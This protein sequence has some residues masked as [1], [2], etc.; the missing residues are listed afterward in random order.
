MFESIGKEEIDSFI[1][2]NGQFVV[3][4][5]EVIYEIPLNGNEIHR[6]YLHSKKKGHPL[7]FMNQHIM[8]S[9]VAHND[10]L[11]RA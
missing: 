6:L 10:I 4:E 11:M 9:S 1:S 5:N 3:F 7:I 8:R 2:F